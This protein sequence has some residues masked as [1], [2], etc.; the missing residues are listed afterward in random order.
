VVTLER[1]VRFQAA[2]EH[3]SKDGGFHGVHIW[4]TL[5]R[6]MPWDMSLF[7]GLAIAMAR[8]SAAEK[9]ARTLIAEADGRSHQ[10][11]S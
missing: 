1:K 8:A 10:E 5:R 3:R 9:A 7:E 6:P 2:Y 4:F 11:Q